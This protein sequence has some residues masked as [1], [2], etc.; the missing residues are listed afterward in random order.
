MHPLKTF[1]QLESEVRSYSRAFPTLFTTA[2]NAHLHDTHG[3][4]YIDFFAG[5]GVINYGHNNPHLKQAIINYMM[6]DG[7]THSLDMS[8]AAKQRFLTTFEQH[9]LQPRHL[10]YKIQ[11]TGPTGT[12]AVEAALKIARK[13]TGRHHIIS[14]TNGYH[15]LTAGA[16]ALTGERYF[17]HPAFTTTQNVTFMPYDGYLGADLNTI[18]YLRTFLEDSASGV[19]LPAAIIVETVQCEGGVNIARATW[20]Q[21]L[22]ALCH[23][24]H[25]LLIVDDI[26]V[27]NGRTGAFFSFEEYN[28]Q[29]DLVTLSKAI[30]G[31]GLPMSILLIK[32]EHDQW[33]PAEHTGTFRGNNLAFVGAAEAIEQYWQTPDF[34][35]ET[36]RKGQHVAATIKSWEANWPLQTRGRG[37]VQGIALGVDGVAKAAAQHAFQNGLIIEACGSRNQVLKILPPLTIPDDVLEEGLQILHHSLAHALEEVKTAHV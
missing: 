3:R 7:I 28:L 32:P 37:L 26:Q 18:D 35:R 11:F 34:S 22:A 15:G 14:F 27:G 24:H 1:E 29:P 13:V 10:H 12:N 21:Q 30:G 36:T 23:Q 4:R 19:D 5:A 9:I 25:I 16:L 33:Q 2:V 20:L 6:D 31:Y 17:R 8:T